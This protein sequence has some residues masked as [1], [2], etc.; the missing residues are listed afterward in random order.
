MNYH[1]SCSLLSASTPT[2]YQQEVCHGFDLAAGSFSHPY[3]FEFIPQI[4]TLSTTRKVSLGFIRYTSNGE[5][6]T[7]IPQTGRFIPLYLKRG[8]FRPV[9]YPVMRSHNTKSLSR[10]YPLKLKREGFYRYTSKG[11]DPD[12]GACPPFHELVVEI[13]FVRLVMLWTRYPCTIYYNR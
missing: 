7:V 3:I 12:C 11:E 4:W 9:K 5:V 6:Y 2:S 1:A 8:G 10:F 13:I